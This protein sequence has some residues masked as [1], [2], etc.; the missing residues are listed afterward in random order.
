M[1]SS[2]RLQP[3][4]RIFRYRVFAGL[5]L[6]TILAAI[7]REAGDLAG[8]GF[9]AGAVATFVDPIAA[10]FADRA[11]GFAALPAPEADAA[12]ILPRGAAASMGLAGAEACGLDRVAV[13][14]F[15]TTRTAVTE[16]AAVFAA[17]RRPFD[18]FALA[19]ADDAGAAARATA[20]TSGA[21]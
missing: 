4:S 3:F 6:T 17:A 7:S 19:E 15:W 1:R 14:P 18:S 12:T 10:G 2:R 5:F 21:L 8:A 16:R 20:C 13:F 9:A 11:A